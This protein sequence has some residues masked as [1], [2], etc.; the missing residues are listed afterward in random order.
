[1][2]E[3][4]IWPN[5]GIAATI[6]G[7]GVIGFE[8]AHM[9]YW[10]NFHPCGQRHPIRSVSD[11]LQDFYWTLIL[12]DKALVLLASE[13]NLFRSQLD[14]NLIPYSKFEGAPLLVRPLLHVLGGFL[15]VSSC[16]LKGLSPLLC[17]VVSLGV[18]SCVRMINNVGQQGLSSAYNFKGTLPC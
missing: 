8:I 18:L 9:N 1:M 14:Q 6:I 10:V 16:N 2:L 15:Q 3:V 5:S 4:D 17:K 11:L 13:S 12:P 7:V